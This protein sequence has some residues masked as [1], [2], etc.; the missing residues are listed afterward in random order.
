[1]DKFLIDGH[2][3]YWHLDRVREWQEKKVTCPIY[4]EV[5]PV[6]FCN[7]KC[8]FC[9]LDFAMQKKMQLETEIFCKRL[10]ELGALGTRSIMFA[11]EGEPL[12]HQD[13]P[14]LIRAAKDS[15]MD[16]SITTNGTTQNRELW[17][18]ILPQLSWLR[19]SVDAGTA[20]IYA[21][22]H[23]VPEALFAKTIDSIKEVVKI[24]RDYNLDVTVGIQFLMIEENLNDIEN[25]IK[26]FS[27]L[28]VDY[29]SLKPYSLHPQMLKRKDTIYTKET[30]QYV[31]EIVARYKDKTNMEINFRKGS[32]EKYMNKKKKFNH[33]RALPFWGYITSTAD[34]YTCSVF[35]GDERFKVGNIYNQDMQ[36]IISGDLRR[37]SIKYGEEELNIEGECRLNCRM[38][39]VNEFLEF[40]ENKPCHVNFI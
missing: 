12:L 9:G 7:H 20:T 19:F 23:N 39:R 38:A 10:K 11:G 18:E 17:K 8:I 6:S 33:C 22:V 25:A 1:M 14:K 4:I 35:I 24:K 13:F 34:F 21:Q 28:E 16:V 37:D 31:E 40:L 32:L 36:S 30:V 3:L 2:K 26:L 29:L 5:S 15:G 27:G